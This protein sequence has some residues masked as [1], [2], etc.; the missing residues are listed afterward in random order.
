MTPLTYQALA[1]IQMASEDSVCGILQMRVAKQA[2]TARATIRHQDETD[3]LYAS[4]EQR[5]R[6][7]VEGKSR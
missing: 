5:A 4:A 6:E 3:T 1:S 2:E 7:Y